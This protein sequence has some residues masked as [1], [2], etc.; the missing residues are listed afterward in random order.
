MTHQQGASLKA[1]AA[2]TLMLAHDNSVNSFDII[3]TSKEI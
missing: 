1:A 3:S 2:L